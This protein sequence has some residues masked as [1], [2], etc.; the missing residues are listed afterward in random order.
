MSGT[1]GGGW[2][3]N[4]TRNHQQKHFQL[5]NTTLTESI[6]NSAGSPIITSASCCHYVLYLHFL[7]PGIDPFPQQPP[8]RQT[9]AIVT[10]VGLILATHIDGNDRSGSHVPRNVRC[11]TC[12]AYTSI[13][14]QTYKH[15]T[16]KSRS[17]DGK[18]INPVLF[19]LFQNNTGFFNLHFRSHKVE[20]DLHHKISV[21]LDLSDRALLANWW[22]KSL[23][24]N[25]KINNKKKNLDQRAQGPRS[26]T[27]SLAC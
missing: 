16:T 14:T 18:T 7:C 25:N 10:E 5:S 6:K 8:A 17:R 4:A 22:L 1:C 11:L 26:W 21:P 20:T 3:K 9:V 13:H 23:K 15:S 12:N 24:L 2:T 19:S 27:F